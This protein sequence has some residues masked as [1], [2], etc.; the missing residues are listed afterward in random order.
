MASGEAVGVGEEVMGKVEMG[1]QPLP[2]GGC[3]GVGEVVGGGGG[4]VVG[5]IWERTRA[6]RRKKRDGVETRM[7]A[8][9]GDDLC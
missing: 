6:G 5:R 9:D 8:M 7:F 4:E 1:I 3:C 2:S